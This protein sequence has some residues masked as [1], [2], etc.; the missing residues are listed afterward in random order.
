MDDPGN[1]TIGYLRGDWMTKG[2]LGLNLEVW[3]AVIVVLFIFGGLLFLFVPVLKGQA[4]LDA[5]GTMVSAVTPG[6]VNA[7]P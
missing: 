2:L 7:L 1:S 6:W 5:V 4:L 3:V